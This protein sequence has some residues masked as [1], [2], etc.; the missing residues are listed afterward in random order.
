LRKLIMGA[1]VA[2]PLVFAGTAQADTVTTTFD[3][4]ADGTVNG[5]DGWKVTGPYD[6]QV[7]DVAGDKALRISN[8]ITAGS[9]GD[10]TFSKPVTKPASEADAANVLVNEFTVKAPDTFVPGLI[11]SIS[12][13]DVRVRG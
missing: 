10:M 13:D 2:L 9:F 8:A 3:G 4:F 12:P 6:Q 5:Q 1:A 11:V 7:V